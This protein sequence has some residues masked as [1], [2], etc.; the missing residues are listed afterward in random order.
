M[1]MD[2]ELS[3]YDIG[4]IY[5]L[6]WARN[7]WTLIIMEHMETKEIHNHVIDQKPIQWAKSKV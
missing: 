6:K 7:Y 4:I 2:N 5:F 1:F 3:K